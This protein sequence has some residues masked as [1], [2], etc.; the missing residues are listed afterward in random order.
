MQDSNPQPPDPK[1]GAL[2]VELIGQA[3]LF[4]RTDR[5]FSTAARIAAEASDPPVTCLQR[6]TKPYQAVVGSGT[7]IARGAQCLPK[8][9]RGGCAVACA[10]IQLR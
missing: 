1:S 10:L 4:Y 8:A 6:Q 5:V 7:V 9:S 3:N 2:S